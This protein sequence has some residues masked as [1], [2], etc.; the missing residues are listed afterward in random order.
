MG[1]RIPP[2]HGLPPNWG[3]GPPS[4]SELT[5]S[6]WESLYTMYANFCAGNESTIADTCLVI[7]N[8]FFSSVSATAVAACMA[9]CN[10][11]GFCPECPD[12][13]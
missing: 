6:D 13:E 4:G 8:E 10:D 5:Q 1:R 3:I 9:T 2:G 7:C 12:E 11:G